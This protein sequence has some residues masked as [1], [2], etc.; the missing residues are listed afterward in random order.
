MPPD[1]LSQG[2]QETVVRHVVSVDGVARL[3]RTVAQRL[4][5]LLA[6]IR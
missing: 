4:V 6:E 3:C 2:A 1:R 5:E